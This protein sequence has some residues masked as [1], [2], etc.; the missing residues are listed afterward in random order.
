MASTDAC[1]TTLSGSVWWCTRRVSA[2][3]W[4]GRCASADVGRGSLLD[5]Q[6]QW[7]RDGLVA[8][9]VSLGRCPGA[10]DP[11]DARQHGA[12]HRII[13]VD[14]VRHLAGVVHVDTHVDV[15]LSRIVDGQLSLIA[16]PDG[17]LQPAQGVIVALRTR[18][19]RI[20]RVINAADV[21]GRTLSASASARCPRNLRCQSLSRNLCRHKACAEASELLSQVATTGMKLERQGEPTD[22]LGLQ[23][24]AKAGTTAVAELCTARAGVSATAGSQQREHQTRACGPSRNPQP[25]HSPPIPNTRGTSGSPSR[26]GA[27]SRYPTVCRL[28]TM[29]LP[30][31]GYVQT[32]CGS[33]R[34]MAR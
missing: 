22:P 26:Y 18:S 12:Q 17:P 10:K 34:P 2:M 32:S 9:A 33:R 25:H 20:G 14:R 11:D 19:T 15:A 5:S 6:P 27:P 29:T 13:G 24:C 7:H 28:R 8:P 4:C 1:D 30:L 31:S 16:R 23:A 21:L 3:L